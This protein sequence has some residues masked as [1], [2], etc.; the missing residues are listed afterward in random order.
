M[1][2]LTMIMMV[3]WIGIG[4]SQT[5]A[6]SDQGNIVPAFVSSLDTTPARPKTLVLAV[7]GAT[8]TFF[9]SRGAPLF[10]GDAD[11][12]TAIPGEIKGAIE[13]IVT[14]SGVTSG[15]I[16]GT[17]GI[18]YVFVKSPV[19]VALARTID[20]IGGFSRMSATNS[21]IVWRVMGAYPRV[22]LHMKNN[23]NYLIPSGDIGATGNVPSGGVVYLAEKYDS[24]WQL[25]INGSPV[26]LSTASNGMPIFNIAQAG[27]VTLL[28]DGTAHRG[29][30]SLELLTL[31]IAVVMT[32]PSGRRKKQVPLNE[33]V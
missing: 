21:G 13:Q 16:L 31:L 5:Q 33:L 29:L 20:G 3:V 4:T 17:Y 2:V 15:K 26:P 11:V 22:M 10:L 24:N 8:S 18:Q 23:K 1:T 6:Q 9:I 28:Y 7:S 30:M 14:G 19:P 32:L 25:L 27:T 12:A